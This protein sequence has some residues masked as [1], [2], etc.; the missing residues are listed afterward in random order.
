MELCGNLGD[1]VIRRRSVLTPVIDVLFIRR[2]FRTSLEATL[3][4][5]GLELETAREGDVG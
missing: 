3:N 4:G 5:F 1:A 2:A